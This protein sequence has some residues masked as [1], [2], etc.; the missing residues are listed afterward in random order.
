M[1][2]GPER[3]EGKKEGNGRKVRGVTSRERKEST[4][5]FTEEIA[6]LK[7]FFELRWHRAAHPFFF[8]PT[9]ISSPPHPYLFPTPSLLLFPPY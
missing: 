3:R 8:P 4:M 5:C 6:S 2:C 9:L 7:A 1:T